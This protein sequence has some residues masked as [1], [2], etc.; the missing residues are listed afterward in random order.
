MY[1]SAINFD[2]WL[3]RSTKHCSRASNSKHNLATSALESRG[4]QEYKREEELP[5]STGRTPKA[6]KDSISTKLSKEELMEVKRQSEKIRWKMLDE[7]GEH[8]RG[9]YSIESIRKWKVAF[10]MRR[11]TTRN[12]LGKLIGTGLKSNNVTPH[13][14]PLKNMQSNDNLQNLKRQH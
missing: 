6:V 4:T 9:I 14:S 1:M 13:V 2:N 7:K 10:D 8:K 5:S 3:E 12:C 11:H